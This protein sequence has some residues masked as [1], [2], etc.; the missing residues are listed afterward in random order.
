[1]SSLTASEVFARSQGTQCS[2]PCECHYCAAPCKRVWVHDEPQGPFVRSLT[3]ALRPANPY[4]CTGCWLFRRRRTTVWFLDGMY[5]DGQ[6]GQD[7]SWWMTA[8]K[9]VVLREGRCPD[10]KTLLLNPPGTF[11]LGLKPEGGR[12]NLLHLM[13]ANHG[14]GEVRAD[15]EF[16]FTVDQTVLTYTIYE[17]EQGLKR[18]PEGLSPGVGAL[19]RFMGPQEDRWAEVLEEDDGSELE[20]PKNIG[21]RPRKGLT[22][23]AQVR[24][25][26]KRVS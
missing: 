21:G 3:N 26:V 20:E 15:R 12:P 5:K 9:S 23:D 17:L 13:K 19:L 25:A 4:V 1:M 7:H 24:R 11:V 22:R 16:S 8:E 2:G 6:A 10:L 14:Q 18:G